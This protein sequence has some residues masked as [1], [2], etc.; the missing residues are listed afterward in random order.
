MPNVRYA[1]VISYLFEQLP[2]VRQDF[3]RRAKQLYGDGLP[4]VLYGSV[5]T[6]YVEDLL[7]RLEG[8]AGED[9]KKTL[10]KIFSLLEVLCSSDDFDTRCLVETGV[11]ES[12][13]LSEKDQFNSLKS[14]MGPKTKQVALQVLR[15]RRNRQG[16]ERSETDQN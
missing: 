3:E 1:D 13:L 11:L 10:H 6:E 9:A 8:P 12:L 7:G 16:V 5:L 15:H 2:N 4:H 14:F